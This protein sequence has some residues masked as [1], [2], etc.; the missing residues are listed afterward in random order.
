MTIV[1][2]DGVLKVKDSNNNVL[3]HASDSDDAEQFISSYVNPEDW[4]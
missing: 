2:E 1:L 4:N 3:Y